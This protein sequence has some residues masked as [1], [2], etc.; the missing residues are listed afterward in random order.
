MSGPC[1]AQVYSFAVVMWSLMTG[2]QPHH[3]MNTMQVQ[4]LQMHSGCPVPFLPFLVAG[5]PYIFS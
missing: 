1:A 3:G 5:Q 4:C 2:D